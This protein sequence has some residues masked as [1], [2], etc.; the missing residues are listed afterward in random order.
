MGMDSTVRVPMTEAEKAERGERLA[1]LLK[2]REAMVDAEKTRRDE[3]KDGIESMDAIIADVATDLREGRKEKRQGD[4]FVDETPAKDKAAE[5]LTKVAEAAGDVPVRW[6]PRHR[7]RGDPARA[8]RG[9]AGCG[10]PLL[11]RLLRARLVPR[12]DV[13][14]LLG[15]RLPL[16]PARRRSPH[17]RGRRRPEATPGHPRVQRPHRPGRR[18]VP[19]GRVRPPRGRHGP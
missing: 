1:R 3:A 6:R 17:P 12:L 5:I 16:Q 13:L 7:R 11:A 18:R 8:P 19:G 10:V 14:P 9:P 2:E 4:L 15:P